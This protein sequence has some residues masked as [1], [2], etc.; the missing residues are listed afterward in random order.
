MLCETWI[1]NSGSWHTSIFTGIKAQE[2]E[3]QLA[4]FTIYTTA[5]YSDLMTFKQ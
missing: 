1:I 2:T 3:S 5:E 4:S